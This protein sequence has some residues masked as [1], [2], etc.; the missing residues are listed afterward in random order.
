MIACGTKREL[1]RV[2]IV[3]SSLIPMPQ[4]SSP[5]IQLPITG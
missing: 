4:A 3:T 2:I 1:L 5:M